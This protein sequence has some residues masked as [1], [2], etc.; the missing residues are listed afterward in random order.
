MSC[1]YL[2]VSVAL[3]EPGSLGEKYRK[4]AG[5]LLCKRKQGELGFN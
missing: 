2:P 4:E 1:L 5:L 3:V